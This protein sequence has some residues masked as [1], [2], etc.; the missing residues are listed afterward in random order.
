MTKFGNVHREIR[1]RNE[2]LKWVTCVQ[3]W[4][5][6][7]EELNERRRREEMLWW[8]RSRVDFLQYGEKKF[9]WFHNKASI[10]KLV[11]HITE[12]KGPDGK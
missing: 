4:D 10:H 7:L 5:G 8:Q 9:S 1:M 2:W 12:L 3:E 6:I 11:N